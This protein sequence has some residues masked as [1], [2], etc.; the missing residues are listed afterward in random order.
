M[1]RKPVR[2]EPVWRKSDSTRR[3][4]LEKPK[5]HYQAANNRTLALSALRANVCLMLTYDGLP[6]LVE[7]HTVGTT[8]AGRPAMSAFQVDGQTN[9]LPIQDWRLFCFDECF[10]VALSKLPSRAPRLEYK[11]GAKQF[12]IIDAEV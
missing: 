8:T 3:I 11:K 12:S 5:N 2:G 1:A 7:I 4:Q 10:N 6:R 9:T